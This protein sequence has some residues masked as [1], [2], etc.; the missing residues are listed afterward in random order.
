MVAYPRYP[1]L[2]QRPLTRNEADYL[3]RT[4]AS[5][6]VALQAFLITLGLLALPFGFLFFTLTGRG[7]WSGDRFATAAAGFILLGLVAAVVYY[8]ALGRQEVRFTRAAFR[9]W[10]GLGI[11]LQAQNAL[12]ETLTITAKTQVPVK[13]PTLDGAKRTYHILAG[14]RRFQLSAGTWMALSEGQTVSIAYAPY[15]DVVLEVEGTP[16]R[17]RIARQKEPDRGGQPIG[18]G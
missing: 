9:T 3:A 12:E 10:R 18:G 15:S 5:L 14:D 6:D 16:E 11:D 4:K 17:L 13:H 8:T 7:G 1:A 2:P